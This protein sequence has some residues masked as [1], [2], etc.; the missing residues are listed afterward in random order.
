MEVVPSPRGFWG[1]PG[2]VPNVPRGVPN[3]PR[4]VP[5]VS[6][7]SPRCPQDVPKCPQACIDE[8]M[9]VVQFLVE[10]G[11]DVNQADNEGWTPLHVAAACG[12]HHIAQGFWG[13][14]RRF[15]DI[16][17]HFQGI[18]GHFIGIFWDF[19]AVLSGSPLRHESPEQQQRGEGIWGEFRRFWGIL[20]HF[21]AFY[22]DFGGFWEVL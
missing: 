8:N 22:G 4:G 10:S 2:S 16:L 11:A 1:V 5:T 17:G 21:G 18:L 7:M 9:E 20:G 19:I 12:C 14:F 6:P 15:W 3:V 13:Q